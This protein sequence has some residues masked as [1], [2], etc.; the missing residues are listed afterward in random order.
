MTDV[1]YLSAHWKL[2]ALWIW[3]EKSVQKYAPGL[4]AP[5]KERSRF[6]KKEYVAY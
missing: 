3:V 4:T 5:L 2:Q 6:Q 1:L